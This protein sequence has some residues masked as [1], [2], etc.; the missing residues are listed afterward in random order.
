MK[1]NFSNFLNK[2]NIRGKKRKEDALLLLDSIA[3]ARL[4]I[5]YE[6]AF[7]KLVHFNDNLAKWVAENNPEHWAMSKFLQKR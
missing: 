3:Y 2:Q 5:N 4:D 7:E 1:K 6:E